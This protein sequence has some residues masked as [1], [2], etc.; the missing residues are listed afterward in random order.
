MLKRRESDWRLRSAGARPRSAECFAWPLTLPGTAARL[1]PLTAPAMRFCI[2][3]WADEVNAIR[4][5]AVGRTREETRRLR[6]DNFYL[7]TRS[8]SYFVTCGCCAAADRHTRIHW[9]E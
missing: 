3:A 6:M 4:R 9:S 5:R 1:L 2:A 7:T 8:P